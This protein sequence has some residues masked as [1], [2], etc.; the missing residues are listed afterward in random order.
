MEQVIHKRL[1]WDLNLSA[2]VPA[3]E[4][5]FDLP[6]S[7]IILDVGYQSEGIVIWYCFDPRDLTPV[8]P[9]LASH[10]F[11][12]FWTGE[13][14]DIEPQVRHL[15]TLQIAGLVYH[16]LHVTEDPPIEGII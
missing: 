6:A 15:K 16:V 5:R 11:Y 1:L 10:G 9:H 13:A 2:K 3:K 4:I 14:F 8:E 7:A 12:I